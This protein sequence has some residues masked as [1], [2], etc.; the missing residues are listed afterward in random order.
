MSNTKVIGLISAVIG[1]IDGTSKLFKTIKDSHDLP[2]ALNSVSQRLPLI[3]AILQAA[4]RRIKDSNESQGDFGP[5][6]T[7]LESCQDQALRLKSTLQDVT[8]KPPTNIEVPNTIRAVANPNTLMHKNSAVAHYGIG[9]QFGN[10]GSGQQHIN[11][12]KGQQVFA[13]SMEILGGIED[14]RKANSL[15]PENPALLDALESTKAAARNLSAIFRAVAGG[16][17]TKREDLYEEFLR[18]PRA[19]GIEVVLL[20]LLQGPHE[21]VNECIIEATV[22]Q[23]H[24]LAEA[25]EELSSLQPSMPMNQAAAVAHYGKGDLFSNLANGHQ[26]I[27]KGTGAQYISERM[28]W[29]AQSSP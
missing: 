5:I 19:M 10:M 27:N 6:Q 28:N 9:H 12:G 4:E 14:Q 23:D 22:D 7:L 21:L 8:M 16:S 15:D 20:Q 11:M 2:D 29:A 24:Q 13:H 3:R 26:N 17:E 1:I 25:I 18:K